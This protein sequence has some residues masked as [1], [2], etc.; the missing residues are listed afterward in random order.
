VTPEEDLVEEFLNGSQ[1]AFRELLKLHQARVRGYLG[2][3]LADRDAV[4][5]LA[6]E[7]FLAAYRDLKSWNR[8][9]PFG[10]WLL[11]IAKNRALHFLRQEGRRRSQESRG[12]GAALTAALERDLAAEGNDEA[13]DREI[14]AMKSCIGQLPEHSGALVREYY[15]ERREATDIARSQQKNQAAVW[16]TLFRIR[17]VLRRCVQS[18]LAAIEGMP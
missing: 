4:E 10:L 2:R 5:D 14:L 8:E 3:F 15:F 7:T 6:Q 9:A 12:F 13:P 11:K 17:Q 16:R 18:K 1:D